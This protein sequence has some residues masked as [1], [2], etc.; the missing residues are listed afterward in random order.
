VIKLSVTPS[1]VPLKNLID[2]KD[3]RIY[4]SHV[5]YRVLVPIGKTIEALLEVPDG[6]VYLVPGEIHDVPTDYFTHRCEKD[7]FKVL[8][9][10][11]IDG[12]SRILNYAEPLLVE[13]YWYGVVKNVSD[14]YAPPGADTIFRLRVPILVIPKA[15]VKRWR[16]EV[17]VEREMITVL[18]DIW[19]KASLEKKVELMTRVPELV[20]VIAR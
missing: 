6:Y 20:T 15:S 9:E 19:Q 16:Q 8:P 4:P 17:E 7:G 1:V 18:M 10:T 12:T 14:V 13:E 5:S 2:H 11:L 3:R